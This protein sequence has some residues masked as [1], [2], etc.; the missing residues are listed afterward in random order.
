MITTI[1]DTPRPVANIHEKGSF[2]RV[3]VSFYEKWTRLN[4][5]GFVKVNLAWNKMRHHD[6][7]DVWELHWLYFQAL[8]IYTVHTWSWWEGSMCVGGVHSVCVPHSCVHWSGTPMWQLKSHLL[9]NAQYL[10][11]RLILDFYNNYLFISYQTTHSA[12]HPSFSLCSTI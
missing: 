9:I 2:I 3:D 7:D 8:I 5:L 11:C 4:Y 10:F 6:G 12:A 1:S